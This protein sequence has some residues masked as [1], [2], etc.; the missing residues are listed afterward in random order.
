MAVKDTARHI[1]DALP[2]EASMDDI[3]HALC[4]NAKIDHGEQEIR[5]GRGVPHDAAKKR[6]RKWVE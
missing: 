4:V 1:I 3:I 2:E 6:P 5:A